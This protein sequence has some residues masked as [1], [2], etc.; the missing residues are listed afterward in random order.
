M[1]DKCQDCAKGKIRFFLNLIDLIYTS[2]FGL[3]VCLSGCLFVSM[4]YTLKWMNRSDQTFQCQGWKQGEAR[5]AV[6]SPRTE[7]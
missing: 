7:R 6:P 5:G 4:K 1:G 3:F 2:E